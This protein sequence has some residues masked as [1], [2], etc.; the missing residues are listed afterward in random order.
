MR[1]LYALLCAA[2]LLACLACNSAGGGDS[3]GLA[4]LALAPGGGSPGGPL[5]P[6]ATSKNVV[7]LSYK[8][9][10]GTT[11]T[12]YIAGYQIDASTGGVTALSG[13]PWNVGSDSGLGALAVTPSGKFIYAANNFS[14]G[15]KT[16]NTVVGFSVNAS[17][18][19]LTQLTGGPW[20]TQTGPTSVAIDTAGKYLYVANTNPASVSGFSIDQTTGALTPITGSP[21][22]VGTNPQSIVID[23]SG[24]Y[25][26]VINMT[27]CSISGFRIT[28]ATGVLTALSG[29]PWSVG[30][31]TF[32]KR[33]AID[34]SGKYLYVTS[35]AVISATG[36]GRVYGY[37]I[38]A[39][40]GALTQ[41]T[42][43]PW[44]TNRTEPRAIIVDTTGAYLY[45]A[46]YSYAELSAFSIDAASGVLTQLT[47]SP[48]ALYIGH[49]LCMTQD[50]AGKYLFTN[51]IASLFSYSINPAT[52]SLS[53]NASSPWT[54]SSVGNVSSI[55]SL[56]LP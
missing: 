26:Y 52:P 45:V 3:S 30:A 19:A 6:A 25:I 1:T 21:W 10:S 55:V 9:D 2:G 35:N 5:P 31:N 12:G 56:Y 44:S 43:S 38:D 27:G 40:S 32:P 54:P 47:G 11:C 33:A 18:G 51:N 7:Y 24:K 49:V 48:L 41:I 8:I 17:T 22:S 4:L 36:Y 14:N 23:K 42:G 28:E 37:S 39:S 29:S 16:V 20:N 46:D 34:T 50:R 13:S 15:T 53:H